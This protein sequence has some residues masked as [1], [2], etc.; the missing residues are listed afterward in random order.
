ME[1]GAFFISCDS[2][3]MIGVTGLL[4]TAGAASDF[5]HSLHL[6]ANDM[7]LRQT[8]GVRWGDQF[9]TYLRTDF[10]VSMPKARRR[11]G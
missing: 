3:A 11:P 1:D 4:G 7:R 6:E 5:S 2:Y 9:F 8:A 10:D